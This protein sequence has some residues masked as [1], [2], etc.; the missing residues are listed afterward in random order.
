MPSIGGAGCQVEKKQEIFSD[1]R[2]QNVLE[3][4]KKNKLLSIEL[5]DLVSL[6]V[7]AMLGISLVPCDTEKIDNIKPPADCWV[8]DVISELEYSIKSCNDAIGRLSE[9]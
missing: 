7:G 3:L 8:E 2:M 4:V 1:K 5:R 9:L 6:K